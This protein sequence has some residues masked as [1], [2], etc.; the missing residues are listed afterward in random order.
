[1]KQSSLLVVD[2]NPG[3]RILLED[4][5]SSKGY[6]VGTA[7]SGLEALEL[8]KKQLP[9]LIISDLRMPGISGIE[10]RERLLSFNPNM[11]VILMS[12]YADKQ[13][14]DELARHYIIDYMLDKPFDLEHLSGVVDDLLNKTSTV[15]ILAK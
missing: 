8:A 14:M 12:A 15:S 1:M 9:D 4:L 2:D 6:K 11:K 7:A 3:I 5:F 13:E 10:L